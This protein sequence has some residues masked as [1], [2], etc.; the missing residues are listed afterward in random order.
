MNWF[1]IIC[2]IVIV[3]IIFL[4]TRRWFWVLVFGLGAVASCF[5]M[6]A[7]IIHFQILWAMG[8]F[9]L[10]VI[11]GIITSIIADGY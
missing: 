4:A 11:L 2:G 1:Y 3:G 6:I 7:S 8:F 5:S 9:I 10:M